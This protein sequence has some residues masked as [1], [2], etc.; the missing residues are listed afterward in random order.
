MG[1][2]GPAPYHDH[3]ATALNIDGEAGSLI[4]GLLTEPLAQVRAFGDDHL[5]A[6]RW[7]AKNLRA[8]TWRSRGC[9]LLPIRLEHMSDAELDEDFEPINNDML[10]HVVRGL[11][12]HETAP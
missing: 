4:F 11:D 7:A 8:T 6:S 9:M 10:G 2:S 5:G 12:L 1:A 3:A